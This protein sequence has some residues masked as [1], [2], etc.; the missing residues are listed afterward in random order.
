MKKITH[1]AKMLIITFWCCSL[2]STYGQN[3]PDINL[4]FGKG[5][6][7]IAADSSMKFNATFRMQSLWNAQRSLE[8]GAEWNTNL[9]IRRARLKFK[10]WAVNPRLKYKVELALSNND[11]NTGSDF[12]Q[13]S[14][15]PKIILDAVLKYKAHKYLEIWAGQT[16]LPGNRERVIS[17]Q[18]LQMV[19]RSLLN[20]RL[21]IDRGI[22]LQFRSAFKIG[23][24]EIRPMFSWDLGEGRNITTGN[25]GGYS[26]TGRV[27]VLPFGAF[28]SKGDY[29]GSDLKREKTPKLAMG[30]SYNYNVGASKQKQSGKFLVDID[31]DYLQNNL[32]TFFADMMFK[33]QGFS[34][35]GEYAHRIV[36]NMSD[37]G[38]NLEQLVDANGRSYYTGDAINIQAG[39][40]LKNNIEMSA[41][42]TKI[43]PDRIASFT[44]T[45]E[46][47]LGLSKYI[48][49]HNLKI[50]T[51]VS[52]IDKETAEHESLRYRVQFEFQF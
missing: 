44:G 38:D 42:Y 27:E 40:L 12:D 43:S 25:I 32:E 22:G 14:G 37:I 17:S 13:T 9:L 51:D 30:L 35:M 28:A 48:V 34:L 4:K 8:E 29:V 2:S 10:G 1:L 11:L 26:Y 50:Q 39:Y 7:I 16:K 19:D 5:L 15:A 46:Y 49:G 21:N 6:T 45:D 47:T 24:S 33:Y 3:T 52:L 23:Q 36:A 31:G 41:R 20:S 18:A